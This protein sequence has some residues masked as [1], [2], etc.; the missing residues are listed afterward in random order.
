L[1]PSNSPMFWAA[2]LKYW[3]ATST[4]ISSR[5]QPLRTGRLD[6]C[7]MGT[8]EKPCPIHAIAASSGVIL[9]DS[10]ASTTD[11]EPGQRGFGRDAMSR[12]NWIVDA[13]ILRSTIS[14][15]VQE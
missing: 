6:R 1:S 2:P 11:I 8:G 9:C 10:K 12:L 15:K 7:G 14:Q 3:D 4:V 13:G 5:S